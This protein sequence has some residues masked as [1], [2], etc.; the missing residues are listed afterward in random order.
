TIQS[1][2]NDS[3]VN[4]GMKNYAP[5]LISG[6]LPV[7]CVCY[8]PEDQALVLVQVTRIR[9]SAGEDQIKQTFFVVDPAHVAAFEFA[10]GQPVKALGLTEP[11]VI[12]NSGLKPRS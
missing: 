12:M 11:P 9:Q 3:I 7:D 4:A 10:D 5:R 1:S 2:G 6:R 8:L